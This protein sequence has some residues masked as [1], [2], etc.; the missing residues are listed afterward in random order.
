VATREVD[1]NNLLVYSTPVV[2]GIAGHNELLA[3]RYLPLLVDNNIRQWL[4]TLP[5]DN[6]DS[7]KL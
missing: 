1:D 2:M 3:T 4:N 5:K 7:C 6:I